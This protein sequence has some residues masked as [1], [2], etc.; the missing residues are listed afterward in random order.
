MRILITALMMTC[1]AGPALAG[2]AVVL[3]NDV[4]AS[5]PVT[6]GDLFDGAGSAAGVIIAPPV[7][8]GSLVLDVSAVQ[9]AASRAGL[10]WS[11]SQGVRLVIIH[12]GAPAS[13]SGAAPASASRPG[14]TVQ[15]LAYS[16]SLEAGEVIQADDLTWAKAVQA[17]AGAPHDAD[18]LIGKAARRPLREG[19]VASIRD[20]VSATV[21]KKGDMVRVSYANEGI[22]LTMQGK[23]AG[24]A[25][26]G[27]PVSVINTATKTAI[28]AIASGPDQAVVG[29][30]AEQIR[31]QTLL[32][33]SQ[34]VLR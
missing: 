5:G 8:S 13:T 14:A 17:P 2:Q 32:N 30:E 24:P 3:K 12:A 4:V 20:G 7:K 9:Q 31:A 19:A 6:L 16:R 10:D 29:P 27:D 26:V 28:Q 11:N 23:A 33:P 34:T 22:S 15:V 21:I 18:Q 25:A 1:L